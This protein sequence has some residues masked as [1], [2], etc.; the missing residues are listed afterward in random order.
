MSSFTERLRGRRAGGHDGD[1][2]M[3]TGAYALGAL[4]DAERAAV[5]R[6]L[7]DCGPCAVEAAE[8]AETASRLGAAVATPP[9]TELRDRVLAAA[10]TTPQIPADVRNATTVTIDEAR[11]PN[12]FQRLAA[13]A[14]AVAVL[15]GAVGTTWWFQESRIADEHAR[16]VATQEEQRQIQ[17]V[18]SAPDARILVASDVPTGRVTAVYSAGR[19]AAVY[20]FGGLAE[21]PKGKTYQ[22]WRVKGTTAPQS[23]GALAAGDRDGS[24]LVRNLD[25]TD[26]VAM[27]IEDA[28]GVMAP[29]HVISQLKMS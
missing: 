23:L 29:T 16:V 20:T 14:A 21:A 22:L 11:P 26:V 7:R 5:E 6:H 13:V 17:S 2:H 28:G 25:S 15:A 4:D 18:L 19:D 1:V 24:V 27:S 9:P 10:R 3:L 8:F 12:R